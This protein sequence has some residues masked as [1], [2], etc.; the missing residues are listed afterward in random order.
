MQ[1]ILKRQFIIIIIPAVCLFLAF[2]LARELN[3]IKPGLFVIPSVLHSL[4]FILSAITAIAGP[5]FFRTLFAHSMR[6]QSQVTAKEFLSFQRK[7]LWISQ[8]TPYFAFVAVL[9]DFPRFFAA[10]IVLMA[11]YAVYYYFPSQKRIDFDR[12]IFRVK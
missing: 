5:L 3:F 6:K 2:G 12:K 10:A 1:P 8:V 11:L 7:I 9:C 4:L